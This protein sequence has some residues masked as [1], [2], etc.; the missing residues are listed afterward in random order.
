M[1]SIVWGWVQSMSSIGHGWVQS[2]S[3]IVHGWVDGAECVPGLEPN[4]KLEKIAPGNSRGDIVPIK[5]WREKRKTIFAKW[6]LRKI[7]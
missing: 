2:M 1:G 4:L 6:S 7:L 3:S 5:I